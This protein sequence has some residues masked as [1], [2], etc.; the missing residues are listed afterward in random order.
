MRQDGRKGSGVKE[1]CDAF[2]LDAIR[3]SGPCEVA[4][5]WGPY[6]RYSALLAP[7]SGSPVGEVYSS[8]PSFFSLGTREGHPEKVLSKPRVSRR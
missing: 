3:M 1:L 6:D 7:K 5:N 4:G 2:P 8:R